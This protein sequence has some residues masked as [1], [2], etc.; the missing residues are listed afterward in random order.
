M[1][2]TLITA[3]V[4]LSLGTIEACATE[5]A[6]RDVRAGTTTT[7]SQ[8]EQA[9]SEVTGGANNAQGSTGLNVP[10]KYVSGS[11]GEKGAS[12]SV[13]EAPRAAAAPPREP[14]SQPRNEPRF[15]PPPRPS[16]TGDPPPPPDQRR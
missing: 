13:T 16:D 9:P 2:L 4:V 15:V 12:A 14:A 8:Q 3:A 7:T 11:G 6:S 1:K 5:G 10:G